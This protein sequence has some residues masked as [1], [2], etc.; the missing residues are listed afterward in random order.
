[1]PSLTRPRKSCCQH[2]VYT[3]NEATGLR[4]CTCWDCGHQ[5]VE[6]IPPWKPEVLS[7]REGSR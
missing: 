6:S 3:A 7:A 2:A 4:R 1:M 5:W